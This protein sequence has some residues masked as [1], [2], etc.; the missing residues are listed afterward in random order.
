M[1]ENE[2]L[3]RAAQHVLM[4]FERLE[5][6]WEQE[7]PQDTN[8]IKPHDT[9]AEV[10]A[11]TDRIMSRL[12]DSAPVAEELAAPVAGSARV[13]A[14]FVALVTAE[15]GE[16]VMEELLVARRQG[17]S[18]PTSDLTVVEL[19]RY[20]VSPD[21]ELEVDVDAITGLARLML[22]FEALE[23]ETS[24]PLVVG[25]RLTSGDLMWRRVSSRGVA[26][27]DDVPIDHLQTV[28]L[29][30]SVAMREPPPPG[31]QSR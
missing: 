30:I 11:A 26:V 14:A 10:E 5:T 21:V 8:D 13:D 24:T 27:F 25:L 16:K 3:H 2:A 23:G 22:L 20:G 9:D 1:T 29:Q 19:V 18:L 7:T 17:F 6:S 28:S 31:Q 12:F 15:F 4:L